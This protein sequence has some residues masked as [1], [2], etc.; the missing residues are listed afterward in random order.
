MTE[1]EEA[2]RGEGGEEGKGRERIAED[3]ADGA[4]S[5]GLGEGEAPEDVVEGIL[6]E[7]LDRDRRLRRSTR[8]DL[9]RF[10]DCG[11][12]QW[13]EHHAIVPFVRRHNVPAAVSVAVA[14]RRWGGCRNSWRR[15]N[16]EGAEREVGSLIATKPDWT[17]I[18]ER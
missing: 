4:A 8:L 13:G 5:H 12:I 2:E 7:E 11:R 15:M 1:G 10:C 18:K 17:R 16:C 3:P 9:R 14:I 6:G